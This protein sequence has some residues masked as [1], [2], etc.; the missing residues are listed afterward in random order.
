MQLCQAKGSR[1]EKVD[2]DDDEIA[3]VWITVKT[4]GWITIITDPD[5]IATLDTT[6]FACASWLK[7]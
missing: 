5:I 7:D 3:S 1:K 2:S 4:S 6:N